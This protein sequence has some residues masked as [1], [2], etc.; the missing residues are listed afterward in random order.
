MAVTQSQNGERETYLYIHQDYVKVFAYAF[1][2][3]A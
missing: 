1:M 2:F 3:V